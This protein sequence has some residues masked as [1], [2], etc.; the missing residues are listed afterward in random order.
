MEREESASSDGTAPVKKHH[1]LLKVGLYTVRLWLA[2]PENRLWRGWVAHWYLPSDEEREGSHARAGVGHPL[3]PRS[4]H[5]I[6]CASPLLMVA[7]A[8]GL[9]MGAPCCMGVP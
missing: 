6:V 2:L 7:C 3:Q 8:A 1:P 4:S 5:V 9:V